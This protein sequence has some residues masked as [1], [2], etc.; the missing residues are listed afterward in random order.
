MAIR[1]LPDS[2]LSHDG[3]TDWRRVCD[4][5]LHQCAAD[6]GWQISVGA[7]PVDVC[8]DD[9]ADQA[10]QRHHAEQVQ[11]AQRDGDPE[12]IAAARAAQADA[13]AKIARRVERDERR[14]RADADL[15]HCGHA[16][17][18]NRRALINAAHAWS[19]MWHAYHSGDADRMAHAYDAIET[20]VH[21]LI[22]LSTELEPGGRRW[23]PPL[24]D[25]DRLRVDLWVV[26]R[27]EGSP[28]ALSAFGDRVD[29]L[30]GQVLVHGTF[31]G[32]ELD[33]LCDALKVSYRCRLEVRTWWNA[34]RVVVG[35]ESGRHRRLRDVADT[36]EIFS[37]ERDRL[38]VAMARWVPQLIE[39]R[40]AEHP[41]LE[42]VCWTQGPCQLTEIRWQSA[43]LLDDA[44]ARRTSD[45]ARALRDELRGV[46]A[47]IAN[48]R[49][50]CL[51]G[52]V[53]DCP[54]VTLTRDGVSSSSRRR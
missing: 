53:R 11:A 12:Q 35:H 28:P 2:P 8:S 21:P 38:A 47:L 19:M 43:D 27:P 40:M 9:C 39:R 36:D 48:A 18:G 14:R 32:V 54:T 46:F 41:E 24:R 34:R 51:V 3:W 45:V 6:S 25:A 5:C 49:V 33:A 22:G 10:R 52:D 1:E 31:S 7:A 50:P 15:A 26:D 23:E 16:I 29:L 4:V 44:Q 30:D 37:G 13:D 20:Y 17:F 42:R